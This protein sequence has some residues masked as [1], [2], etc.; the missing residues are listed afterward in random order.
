[1]EAATR[2]KAL[3]EH[4]DRFLLDQGDR[5]I[6]KTTRTFIPLM[7]ERQALADQLARYLAMLGLPRVAPPSPSLSEIFNRPAQPGKETK[8]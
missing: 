1:V 8:P 4:A 6:N 3:L 7:R 2:K 5:I